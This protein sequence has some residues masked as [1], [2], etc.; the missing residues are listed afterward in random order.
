MTITNIF[1]ETRKMEIVEEENYCVSTM[2]EL[3]DGNYEKL[4]TLEILLPED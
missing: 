2:Y 4:D 1:S 3:V